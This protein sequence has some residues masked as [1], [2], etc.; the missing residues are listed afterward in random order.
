MPKLTVAVLAV[1]IACSA[2]AAGWRSLRID[3]SSEA[4]FESSVAAM[5]EKLS[6]GRR[7]AFTMALQDV[8]VRGAQ[9]ARADQ[10]GYT[11]AH[12]LRLLDGLGYQEVRAPPPVEGGVYRGATRSIDRRQ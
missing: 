12:Y 3:G 10:P 1:V 9:S 8:W 5:K 6:P 4:S 2:S 11:K 7:Y